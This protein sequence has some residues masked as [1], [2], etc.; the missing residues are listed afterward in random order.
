MKDGHP[1]RKHHFIGLFFGL[2]FM[3]LPLACTGGGSSGSGSLGTSCTADEECEAGYICTSV[4]ALGGRM[5]CAPAGGLCPKDEHDDG[6]GACVAEGCA[7]GYHD[8]GLGECV[9]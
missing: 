5:A 9:L 8:S 1:T 4:A 7:D 6:T 2:A 3:A